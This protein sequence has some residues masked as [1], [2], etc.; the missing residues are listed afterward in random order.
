MSWHYRITCY[1][2]S[3][4]LLV[5]LVS[6]HRY[7][8]P[9]VISWLYGTPDYAMISVMMTLCILISSELL[10]SRSCTVIIRCALC[11]TLLRCPVVHV[12]LWSTFPVFRYI[13][14][15]WWCLCRESWSP[16]YC[17]V[18]TLVLHSC[19]PWT[20]LSAYGADYTGQCFDTDMMLP[21]TPADHGLYIP[22]LSTSPM[23]A[24]RCRGDV[25]FDVAADVVFLRRSARRRR[26]RRGDDLSCLCAS[27]ASC[28]WISTT[29]MMGL[30]SPAPIAL[31]ARQTVRE[32]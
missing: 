11:G 8:E 16:S 29:P 28:W 14:F 23:I 18:A 9:F 32:W 10:Y 7:V 6:I 2:S 24:T 5:L 19:S 13:L 21:T 12:L 30:S 1:S 25:F 20:L 15:V 4:Q 3:Q 27:P 26:C 22:D 31:W 17:I